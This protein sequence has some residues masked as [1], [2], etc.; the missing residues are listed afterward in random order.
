MKL[1]I[2]VFIFAAALALLASAIAGP[3]TR[4]TLAADLQG[5]LDGVPYRIVTQQNCNGT[6]HR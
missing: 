3:A 4:I 2:L 6:L 1:R 5:D